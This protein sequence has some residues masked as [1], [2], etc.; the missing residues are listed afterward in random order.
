MTFT[1]LFLDAINEYKIISIIGLAK[2]VSKTTTLNHILKNLKGK[3]K[4]GLT[5]IGRD[6]ER[7]D[8]ISN[9]PK[10][11]IFVKKG[12][13][14]ATA[15]E[16][17]NNSEVSMEIVKNT[18]IS[19]PMGDVMIVKAVNEGYVEIA[20]PSINSDL[21][22]VCLELKALGCDL[23]LIDGAFDRKSY[24]APLISDATIL[25]TGAN[26]SS[27]LKRVVDITHHTFNLLT[28]NHEGNPEMIELSRNLLKKSAVSIVNS[29]NSVKMLNVATALDA[30]KEITKNLNDNSNYVII[31]GAMTDKLLE[32]LMTLSENYKK[33]QF[34][35][36]N[37]T[38]LFL[39]SKTFEKFM[40][41]GGVLKVLSPIKII[42]ITINPTSP[43]GGFKFN[44]RDF[45]KLLENRIN[46]PIFNLGPCD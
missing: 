3:I 42:A 20:G 1:N 12:T 23:I 41:K 46:I 28:L 40:K 7:Y 22:N 8:V 43:A 9:F 13:Y 45:I 38:K 37:G 15:Q 29:D 44:E 5:S 16:C 25:S 34:L 33:V 18:G 35:V 30:A 10:P 26:V 36:E 17:Y 24:A 31:R 14:I 11:R 39:S 19:T 2:N 6:G 32:E 21:S 27:D 4:L